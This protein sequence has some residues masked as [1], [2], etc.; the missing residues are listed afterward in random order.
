MRSPSHGACNVE[1]TQ[2][3]SPEA[4]MTW[5]VVLAAVATRIE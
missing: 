5:A 2:L 3:R 4:T 1:D